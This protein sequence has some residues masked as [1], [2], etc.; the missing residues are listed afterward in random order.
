MSELKDSETK[1]STDG[2][3]TS[4]PLAAAPPP[5]AASDTD[6]QISL[7]LVETPKVELPS[8]DAAKNEVPITDTTAAAQS[9]EPSESLETAKLIELLTS[10]PVVPSP[11]VAC[12]PVKET[13]TP[14]ITLSAADKSAAAPLEIDTV[15]IAKGSHA[16]SRANRFALLAASVAVAA[17]VGAL[18]GALGASLIMKPASSSTETPIA[19]LDQTPLQETLAS[20]RNDIAA[21]KASVDSGARNANAQFAKAAERF[22]RI[23]RAQSTTS[24]QLAKSIEALDRRSTASRDATGSVRPEPAVLPAPPPTAPQES[25]RGPVLDGWVVRNVNRN[26]AIIQGRRMGAIEVEAGDIV[27]GVGR[28]QAIRKQPDGKW[29]VVTSKGLITSAR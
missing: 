29:V 27:P 20:V 5:A 1:A 2:T 23:E 15:A 7:A 3:E 17:S 25:L 21:M 9:A 11:A 16:S 26:V 28:I 14:S 22:E 8:V 18:A 19:A 4:A 12:P 10:E 13:T 6:K 24:A